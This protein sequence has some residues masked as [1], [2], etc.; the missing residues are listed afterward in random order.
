MKE[1]CIKISGCKK[2]TITDNYDWGA[3]DPS[4][5][6]SNTLITLKYI[7]ETSTGD[8]LTIV[9]E[10]EYVSTIDVLPSTILSSW[11]KIQDGYYQ[12]KSQYTIGTSS[13][14]SMSF[15]LDVQPSLGTYSNFNVTATDG[16]NFTFQWYFNGSL[17]GANTTETAANMVA[18]ANTQFTSYFG[19]TFNVI[20]SS[21]GNVITFTTTENTT[22][23]NQHNH[24]YILNKQAVDGSYATGLYTSLS[25]GSTTI[26]NDDIYMYMS[27][28]SIVSVIK[29]NTEVFNKCNQDCKID[30]LIADYV[31]DNECDSCNKKMEQDILNIALKSELLCYAITCSSKS[32]VWELY[33]YI[34]NMLTDY[35]CKSC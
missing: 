6:V 29:T 16:S 12:I 19:Y 27:G 4:I 13:P 33:N 2:L 14:G 25:G 23:Y 20:A 15:S 9:N 24:F 32:K 5:S 22:F 10:D 1:I 18:Y 11:A 35:N 28:G 21:V 8:T 31:A 34:N 3:T 26:E 30:N 7:S 17:V